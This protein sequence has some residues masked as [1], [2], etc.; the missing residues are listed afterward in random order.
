MPASGFP[1]AGVLM[2]RLTRLYLR[3]LAVSLALAPLAAVLYLQWFQDPDLLFDSHAVHE[4]AIALAIATSAFV[5][6]VTWLCHRASGEP[7]LRWLALAFLGFTAVYALHGVYTRASSHHMALFLI[8]GPV[9]RLVMA[10]LL[11]KGLLVYGEPADPPERRGGLLFWGG[12]LAGF[13]LLDLLLD[14]LGRSLPGGRLLLQAVEVCAMACYLSS[15]VLIVRRGLRSPMMQLYCL[16]LAFFAQAS[17]GFLLARPWNHQW[18]MAHAVFGTGFVV[19]SHGVARAFLTTRTLSGIYGQE[20]IMRRLEA[21]NQTALCALER[22]KT[23]NEQL[24]NLAATDPLTGVSNRRDLLARLDVEVSRARRTGA[25]LS[26]LSMDLDHF[27][28]INDT[29]GHQAG[30]AALVAFAGCVHAGL[31][32]HDLFGRLGGEEFLAVLPGA[33]LPEAAHTAERLRLAVERLD[34][35]SGGGSPRLTVSI[36]A[37]QFGPDGQDAEEVCKAADERLYRAKREGR[38]RVAA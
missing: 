16:S 34:V 12:W 4:L 14:A 37:A 22:L 29:F 27:K 7:V 26:V 18:W 30:D 36:G 15:I 1:G 20:E 17:L 19:L 24:E 32:A 8:Y 13:A 5:S 2:E 9:A 31:R 6:L 10:G 21:A 23:A 28:R 11:L 33:A 3:M 25:P 35:R 38:N